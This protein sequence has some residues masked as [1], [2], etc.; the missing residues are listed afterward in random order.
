VH[1]ERES[2]RERVGQLAREDKKARVDSREGCTEEGGSGTRKDKE[3]ESKE[4]KE[5]RERV[6]F[7]PGCGGC[8]A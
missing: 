7:C 4:G 3:E 5:N 2:E 1:C 8:C 6:P